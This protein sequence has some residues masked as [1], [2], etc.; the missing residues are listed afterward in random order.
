MPVLKLSGPLQKPS[1]CFKTCMYIHCCS[2]HNIIY[3]FVSPCVGRS[4]VPPRTL[5]RIKVVL[6]DSLHMCKPTR[7]FLQE[8]NLSKPQNAY[9]CILQWHKL[10]TS[11]LIRYVLH[12]KALALRCFAPSGLMLYNVYVPIRHDVSNTYS[13]FLVR[14]KGLSGIIC[15]CIVHEL[16]TCYMLDVQ[17]S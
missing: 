14:V 10:L 8:S 12:H 13:T 5:Y 11:C 4:V 6:A 17:S 2:C 16:W 1:N 7:Q 15:M 3:T 9:N